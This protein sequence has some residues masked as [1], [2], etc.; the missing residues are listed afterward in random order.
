MEPNQK[1]GPIYL[2][3]FPVRRNN[4][5]V[6]PLCYPS[7]TYVH[8]GIQAEHQQLA[9]AG[10]VCHVQIIFNNHRIAAEPEIAQRPHTTTF[11]VLIFHRHHHNR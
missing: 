10:D 5:R 3:D 1:D 2:L 8:M 9:G 7:Y 4:I 11:Q 6:T